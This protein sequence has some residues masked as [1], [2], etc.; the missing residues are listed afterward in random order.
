MTDESR[1]RHLATLLR[2]PLSLVDIGSDVPLDDG[3]IEFA[4]SRHRVGPLLYQAVCSHPE[5][6]KNSKIV[7]NLNGVYTQNVERILKQKA[8]GKKIGNILAKQGISS[9]AFKGNNLAEQ[10]YDDPNVRQSKDLDILVSPGDAY[11]AITSLDRSGYRR[12]KPNASARRIHDRLWIKFF[13]DMVF[14]DPQYGQIIELHRK[15]MNYE[16]RDFSAHFIDTMESKKKLLISDD[17]YLLYLILHGAHARWPRLKWLC[18]M[19][20]IV[21][22]SSS[23]QKEA[24]FRLAQECSCQQAIVASLLFIEGYFPGSLGRE[25]LDLI[26]LNN[27]EKKSAILL[28]KFRYS[29]NEP[30]IGATPVRISNRLLTDERSRDVFEGTLGFLDI[31]PEKIGRAILARV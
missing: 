3:F 8:A 26:H 13:K 25:W 17:H 18:D 14:V 12:Q 30:T 10:I 11:D 20:L 16:P 1:L 28:Q 7:E 6:S 2:E 31:M 15:L 23:Q 5:L 21:R 19:S 4:K 9:I 24:V 22:K 27:I 29:L